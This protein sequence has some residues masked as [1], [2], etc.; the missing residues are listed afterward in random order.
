[1]NIVNEILQEKGKSLVSIAKAIRVRPA[2]L[3]QQR[4]FYSEGTLGHRGGMS[5][6]S[7]LYQA[8]EKGILSF[9]YEISPNIPIEV[10]KGQRPFTKQMYQTMKYTK[11]ECYE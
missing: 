10:L 6:L 5:L 4:R 3:S 2:A 7:G 11:G 9:D 1:M 8:R